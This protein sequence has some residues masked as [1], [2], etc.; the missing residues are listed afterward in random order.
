MSRFVLKLFVSVQF[1]LHVYIV[2]FHRLY[3][4]EKSYGTMKSNTINNRDGYQF[5]LNNLSSDHS[6][7]VGVKV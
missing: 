1:S 4:D 6:Y 3:T 5:Y 2:L 7:E